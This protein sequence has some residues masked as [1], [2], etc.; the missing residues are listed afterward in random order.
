MDNNAPAL[1]GFA[2]WATQWGTNN[3]GGTMHDYEPDGVVNWIEYALGGNPTSNDAA[4]IMPLWGIAP[5]GG[6]NWLYYVYNRRTGAAD[7]TYTVWS[8][9]GLADG[10]SNAVPAWSVSPPTNGYETATHR[11][12]TDAEPNG[13]MQLQIELSE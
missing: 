2:L 11:I 4:N 12:P 1:E 10:L 5:D 13:F 9:T 8:G 6:S 3:I 7:L